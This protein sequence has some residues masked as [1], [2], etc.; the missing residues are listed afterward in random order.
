MIKDKYIGEEFIDILS[1]PKA[2]RREFLKKTGGAII[3][4][5]TLGD[6]S[7]LEGLQRQDNRPEDFNAYFRIEANGR[8][9]CLT[10]K[11]EL[12]QGPTTSLAQMAADELDV[13][14][15]SI[16]MVLGDTDICPWDSGTWG[17]QTIRF[18]GPVIREAAAK[19]RMVLLELASEQLKVPIENLAT[20][21]GVVFEKNKRNNSVTYAN[22]A[23]GK[24]IKREVKGKVDLKRYPEFKVMGKPHLRVDSREKVTG[25][26]KY[27]GDIR[28]PGML[29]AKIL[30][31][32][33]HDAK[34]K[35]VDVSGV[36]NM[37]DVI[38]VQEEDLT[39]VLHENPDG[40]AMALSKIKA[41]YDRPEPTVDDKT[42][43]EH[44]LKTADRRRVVEEKGDI[45]S[46]EKLADISVEETYLDSYF[47][48]APIETHTALANIEGDKITVWVSTQGPFVIKNQ[49]A[50]A[51]GFLPEKVRVITPFVG[52]GFGGKSSGRQA[53]EAAKLAKITR[54]PVQVAWTREE[55]FFYDTFRPAAVIKIK[56]GV[57]KS[58]DIIFWDYNVYYA[59]ERGANLF[60][61]IPNY[62]TAS[63]SGGDAHPFATGA[64]RAPGNNTNTFARESQIDIM[65][66]K[67][68]IDPVEF[69]L[70]HLKNER[71]RKSLEAA[72]DKF[73][74]KPIKSPSGRGLGVA[75]GSDVG[76]FVAHIAEVEVDKNTGRVQVKRV[77][78]G[79]EMGISINPQGSTIQIEG[80]I[81]MGLGYALTEE[82]HFKGG[83]IL[84]T[85]FDTYEIA[86]FSMTPKIET[87]IV[88]N[89]ETSPQGGGEPAIIC[90]GAVI[91]A[92]TDAIGVR[93][94]Q[95]PL[96][97]QRILE[98]I[99]RG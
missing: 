27:A 20:D 82:I 34:L 65:A 33:A 75:M 51:I 88:D 14:M 8:I 59:G 67:A 13:L 12:G 64:W 43:H 19:T 6:I 23:K 62:I 79:Q 92:I 74:W 18:T 55:E 81:N 85:N 3:V 50:E 46:G 73:G 69:R 9:R 22:L 5:C 4:L 35:S 11:V 17:S 99:K 66:S 76:S 98:A 52:G 49:I 94:F 28:L 31:P 48:H 83:E 57:T 25:K 7:S 78:C 53:I 21:K 68:G 16:D 95:L 77:V 10:G 70:K 1:L 47:A 41:N 96:I 24:I 60:Y 45:K 91:A 61:E 89:K 32:P 80:C 26:A 87:V 42:I 2:T 44:L 58:G 54:K 37:K 90:M 86:R 63:S 97:P 38:L 84:N 72:A 39:A 56:S 30:R 71:A 40:A 15:E 93:V 36:K 29:Y